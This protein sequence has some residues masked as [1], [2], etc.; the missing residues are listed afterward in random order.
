VG[1][2]MEEG[3]YPITMEASVLKI[4]A[5]FKDRMRHGERIGSLNKGS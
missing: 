3:T 5:K 1:E 2:K 4:G